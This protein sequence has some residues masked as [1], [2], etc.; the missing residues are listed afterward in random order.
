MEWIDVTTLPEPYQTII[1]CYEFFKTRQVCS[2][3]YDSRYNTFYGHPQDK[4]VIALKW[5]PLPEA[6]K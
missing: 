1:I 6:P 4:P 5:M 3:W 2:G